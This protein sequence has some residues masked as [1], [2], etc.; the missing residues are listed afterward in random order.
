[1]ILA[2]RHDLIEVRRLAAVLSRHHDRFL[3]RIYH[4]TERDYCLALADPL[5]SLAARFAAK[6]AFIKAWG[7]VAFR[8]VWVEKD[9]PKPRLAL[10]PA[11]EERRDALGLRL[12]LSLSHTRELASAVLVLEGP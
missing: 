1:M 12:H 10:A 9:G 8:D 3:E 2:V 7:A 5:P 4:P 6:E 11:L